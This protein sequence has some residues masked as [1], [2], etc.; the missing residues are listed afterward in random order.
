MADKVQAGPLLIDLLAGRRRWRDAPPSALTALVRAARSQKLL[1]TLA[2]CVDAPDA[3]GALVAASCGRAAYQRTRLVWEAQLLAE[4]LEGLGCPLVLLKGAAYAV[5]GASAAEG[6]T[7]GDL[8]ALVPRSWLGAVEARLHERGWMPLKNDPYDDAYYR[9]WMHEIPPLQHPDR[10]L[11]LDLH[12]TILPL[13]ARI[14]PDAARFVREAVGCSVTGA[15]VPSP[16][17]QVIHSALHLFHDGDLDGGLRNLW[18]IHCLLKDGA[19]DAGFDASLAAAMTA[20]GAGRPLFYALRY[21]ARL[22]D[23]ALPPLA[24]AA[25]AR[26]KPG[27]ATG[28]LMDQ[29]VLSRLYDADWH[30]RR[31]RGQLAAFAL[32]IRSHWLK[33]PPLMLARHLGTKAYKRLAQRRA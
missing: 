32:Y 26:H 23:T 2:A 4:D 6:R 19:R 33:M 31:W 13:T 8:D 1:A 14:R 29:L 9:R 15:L 21:A 10:A 17:D 27:R 28:W 7:T 3:P 25:A 11:L 5:R 20:H 16:A 12:H 24:A 30:S 22:F 18:D